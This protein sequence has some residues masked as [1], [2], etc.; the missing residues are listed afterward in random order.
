MQKMNKLKRRKHIERIKSSVRNLTD[1]LSNF[2]SLDK[3][4]Q[5]K[6]ETENLAF[7]INEFMADTIEEI[8]NMLKRKKQK[9][10]YSHNGDG[11]VTQDKKILRNIMLNLLSNAVK[12][13]PEEKDIY[14]DVD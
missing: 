7:N 13:S 5:G 9:I 10:V 12:Y 6:I 3:L 4:D 2:L 1:I 8:D 11:E 14:I